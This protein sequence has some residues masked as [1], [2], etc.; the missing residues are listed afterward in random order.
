ML[1]C[2]KCKEIKPES[3]FSIRK[4]R[5]RGYH[6]RCK[7]CSAKIHREQP[8]ND[9]P[10]MTGQKLCT[11]CSMF[12]HITYFFANRGHKDGRDAQCKRCRHKTRMHRL[13]TKPEARITENLR[14]RTRA[15]LEGINKSDNTLA[16]I[17]CSPKE[18]K[19]HLESLFTKGMSWSNYGKWHIDHIKPC[20]S[21]D[22]T[23]ESQQRECFNYQN[24]QPLWARDNLSKGNKI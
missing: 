11:K 14:R 12:N 9:N 15:V 23:I 3:S 8:K 13:N 10:Q 21:F 2:S 1:S 7:P 17:G 18:L 5:K 16:L 19:K 6:S 20:S 4:D 22:L 24:L